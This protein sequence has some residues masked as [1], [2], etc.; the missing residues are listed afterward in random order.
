[1]ISIRT[2][3]NSTE[4]IRTLFP[5]EK[6]TTRRRGRKSRKDNKESHIRDRS[7][8]QMGECI[9]QIV[10]WN[11]HSFSNLSANVADIKK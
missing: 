1:M 7:I 4:R 8:R 10:F 6:L 3:Q 2:P 5:P 11:V 9:T